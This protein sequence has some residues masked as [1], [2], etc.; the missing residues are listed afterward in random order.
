MG[1]P[2]LRCG[3]VQDWYAFMHRHSVLLGILKC[4]SCKY[5]IFCFVKINNWKHNNTYDFNVLC[6]YMYCIFFFRKPNI[7]YNMYCKMLELYIIVT[8]LV[9]VLYQLYE[10]NVSLFC[11]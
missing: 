9:N 7:V 11:N 8:Q 5:C 1:S 4:F 6:A 10:I 3:K 2:Q